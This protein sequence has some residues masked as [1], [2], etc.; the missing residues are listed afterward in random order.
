MLSSSTKLI[1]LGLTGLGSTGIGAYFTP[2]LLVG[3]NSDSD[4]IY[5]ESASQELDRSFS[6][7]LSS[8]QEL[9]S[10]LEALISKFKTT[11]GDTN[12]KKSKTH[13]EIQQE[14]QQVSETEGKLQKIYQESKDILSKL[15]ESFKKL[16]EM[17]GK[18]LGHEAVLQSLDYSNKSLHTLG[19]AIYSWGESLE[20]IVC[21]L[22]NKSNC[23][24]SAKE[25]FKKTIDAAQSSV[26]A[27]GGGT[28]SSTNALN[29]IKNSKEELTKKQ[30]ELRALITKIRDAHYSG[31]LQELFRKNFL[32]G[33]KDKIETKKTEIKKIEAE[34]LKTKVDEGNQTVQTLNESYGKLKDS[35]RKWKTLKS[36]AAVLGRYSGQLQHYLCMLSSSQS[37]ALCQMDSVQ[38]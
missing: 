12:S 3:K 36:N 11:I 17:E 9:K 33:F 30:T 13:S 22:D 20:K 21:A 19:S 16:H 18:R 27:Q 35:N 38:S 34:E 31:L 23:D 14:L 10:Q 8:E 29:Q 5:S 6:K 2:Q 26:S 37:P 15:T 28:E 25:W 4:L 7:F 32:T 1:S 24:S